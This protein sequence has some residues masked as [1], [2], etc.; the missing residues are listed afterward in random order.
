MFQLGGLIFAAFVT[1]YVGFRDLA[2]NA[3]LT[4]FER[5]VQWE[6]TLSTG[7]Y[8]AGQ[9]IHFSDAY[10]AYPAEIRPLMEGGGFESL[11]LIGY[12]TLWQPMKRRSI[13]SRGRHG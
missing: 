1:R 9:G 11:D 6:E 4:L 12:K 3:P 10:F 5:R 2:K 7:T 8:H 13:N